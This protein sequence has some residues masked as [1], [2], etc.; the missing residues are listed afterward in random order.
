MSECIYIKKKRKIKCFKKCSI[1][2]KTEPISHVELYGLLVL[3]IFYLLTTT[4]MPITFS[5]LRRE[6]KGSKNKNRIV[7]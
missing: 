1:L 6:T 3:I 2:L 5:G 4:M 7:L